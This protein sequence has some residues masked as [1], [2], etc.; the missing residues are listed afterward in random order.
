MLTGAALV[1]PIS[2]TILRLAGVYSNEQQTFE[3]LQP[4]LAGALSAAGLSVRQDEK[5]ILVSGYVRYD[6]GG[7][8]LL[9]SKP[10]D[11]VS[12]SDDAIK[13]ARNKKAPD[14]GI[15]AGS[16]C[17]QTLSTELRPLRM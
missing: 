5:L 15:A 16:G 17:V 13:V 1:L 11:P 6:F 12:V 14:P 2:P 9:C 10:F 3:V 7:T 4:N 8:R